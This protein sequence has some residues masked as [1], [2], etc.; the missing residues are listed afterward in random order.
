MSGENNTEP[1]V[2][3]D[4]ELETPMVKKPKSTREKAAGPAAQVTGAMS[5]RYNKQERSEK[6]KLIE[7]QVTEGASK[8]KDAIRSAG[9][10]EQTY[11]NW[12]RVVGSVI[13]REEKPAPIGD[14]L[15]DLAKLKQENQRL[16]KILAEK[17]HAENIELRKWLGLD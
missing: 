1:V 14:K 12:K 2:G 9:I 13:L 11:Y 10:S 7:R 8:L 15:V 16:R 4:A 6:L 3:A 5:R 17:L